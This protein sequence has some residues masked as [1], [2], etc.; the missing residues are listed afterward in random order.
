MTLTRYLMSQ[1]QKEES[2]MPSL[3]MS[4]ALA[5]QPPLPSGSRLLEEKTDSANSIALPKLHSVKVAKSGL[6]LRSTEA[7]D[8]PLEAWS[9]ALELLDDSD[10]HPDGC[11][12][13]LE[14]RGQP[15]KQ[16]AFV[17]PVLMDL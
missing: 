11:W 5:E 10:N 16:P 14:L 8:F 15:Q 9:V 12:D 4:G 3:P 17:G 6:K 2:S 1:H 13:V 7:R